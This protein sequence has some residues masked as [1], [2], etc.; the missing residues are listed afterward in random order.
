MR[1]SERISLASETQK[2]DFP[3]NNPKKSLNGAA[4]NEILICMV[5]IN[6]IK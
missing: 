2:Y 6:I 5:Y 4:F 1:V 3:D